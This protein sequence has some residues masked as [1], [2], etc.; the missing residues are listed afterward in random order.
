MRPGGP[1]DYASK[2]WNGLVKDYYHERAK[3]LLGLGKAAAA[4]GKAVDTDAMEALMAEHAYEFQVNTTAYPT[5]PTSDALTTSKAMRTKHAS[6]F[7][8]C[9]G[10]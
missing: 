1:I 10:P 2:H 5:T 6:L 7:A 4:A 9:G 8:A 3:R